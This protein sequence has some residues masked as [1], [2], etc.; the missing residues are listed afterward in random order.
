MKMKIQ[1][2]SSTIFLLICL[3]SVNLLNLC[4]SG[5]CKLR[6]DLEKLARQLRSPPAG[7]EDSLEYGDGVPNVRYVKLYLRRTSG[8]NCMAISQVT[9]KNIKGENV[10]LNKPATSKSHHQ[11][12]YFPKYAV[13]GNEKPRTY[14]EKLFMSQ[15]EDDQWL[16]IDLQKIET[17]KEVTVVNINLPNVRDYIIQTRVQLMD[18]DKDVIIEYLIKNG[19]LVHKFK[20]D[21]PKVEETPNGVANVRFFR[22]KAAQSFRNQLRI[23]QIVLKN[24]QGVNVAKGKPATADSVFPG[25]PPSNANDGTEATKSEPSFFRSMSQGYVRGK[26]G[27]WMVDLK[28]PETIKEIVYYNTANCCQSQIQGAWFELL[29]ADKKVIKK[30]FVRYWDDK[31]VFKTY[32]THFYASRGEYDEIP[33]NREI[34]IKSKSTG[35]CLYADKKIGTK[36]TLAPCDVLD[37]NQIFRVEPHVRNTFR[38]TAAISDGYDKYRMFSVDGG[39]VDDGNSYVQAPGADNNVNLDF[40]LTIIKAEQFSIKNAKTKKCVTITEDGNVQQYPCKPGQE[41]QIFTAE[42]DYDL[43]PTIPKRPLK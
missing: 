2:F 27:W 14:P 33:Y 25:N 22:V 9:V 26:E 8:P 32:K 34:I 10:S 28:Q 29:D 20:T 36:F 40:E 38:L 18:V 39:K 1:I 3:S 16:L 19:D 30:Y 42:S 15:C 35:K 11:D 13:N 7:T 24:S 43:Y 12:G 31:I 5:N 21:L 17:V 4:Q 41:N 23:S 6:A 37:Y